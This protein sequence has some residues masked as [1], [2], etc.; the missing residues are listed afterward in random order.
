MQDQRCEANRARNNLEIFFYSVNNSSLD[1]STV[2]IPSHICDSFNIYQFDSTTNT[3]VL[4]KISSLDACRKRI[5]YFCNIDS[6]NT[7]T[8]EQNPSDT[9][10]GSTNS[11]ELNPYTSIQLI[12]D[13][14]NNWLII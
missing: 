10:N 6:S 7:I 3:I 12:S 9:I 2:N 11:F 14:F 4:P 1:D 5:F 13:T 8:I